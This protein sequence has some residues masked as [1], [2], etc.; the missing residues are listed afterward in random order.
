MQ[1]N[2]NQSSP[3]FGQL[4]FDSKAIE[5]LKARLTSKADAEKIRKLIEAQ[6][7]N[8]L[9]TEVSAVD[10][11]LSGAPDQFVVSTHYTKYCK[12]ESKYMREWEQGFIACLLS[13]PV[14]F[15]KKACKRADA[16]AKEVAESERISETLKDFPIHPNS[17]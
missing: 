7:K 8:P 9:R 11:Y 3:S 6:K 1:I 4:S 13:T 10:H 17:Y 16:L 15:I 5:L 14:R 12:E 2:S